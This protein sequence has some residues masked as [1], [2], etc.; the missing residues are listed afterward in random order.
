MF[1]ADRAPGRREGTV[2]LD[3]CT[4]T[5]PETSRPWTTPPE[6]PS[7]DAGSRA[8]SLTH[9]TNLRRRDEAPPLPTCPQRSG[10]DVVVAYLDCR[11]GLTRPSV[12]APVE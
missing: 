9:A 2:I 10:C 5:V 1:D 3:L 11:V 7:G 12:S 6:R 4:S 8:W